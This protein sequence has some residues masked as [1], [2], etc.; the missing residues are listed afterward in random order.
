VVGI[1]VSF[2]IGIGK[3]DCKKPYSDDLQALACD[4]VRAQV[5]EWRVR[6]PAD[7][8]A[9]PNEEFQ[10]EVVENQEVTFGRLKEALDDGGTLVVFTA[11]IHT[12]SRPTFL[13]LGA[14]GRVYAEGLVV[15]SSGAVTDAPDELLWAYR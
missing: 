8:S 15:T 6:L 11:L 9:F 7:L 1:P 5:D 14:V 13:S 10:Q 12:W 2:R 3:C 4:A